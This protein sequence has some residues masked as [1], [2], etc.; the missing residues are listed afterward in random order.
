MKKL[1]VLLI[2]I[3]IACSPVPIVQSAKFNEGPS[4]SGTL[5]SPE[6][7]SKSP[8]NGVLV[9]FNKPRVHF[10]VGLSAMNRIEINGFLIPLILF[11]YWD[12]NIK[13]YL[14]T[15]GNSDNIFQ[16]ISSSCFIHSNGYFNLAGSVGPALFAGGGLILGTSGIIKKQNVEI[17]YM[18]SV[19]MHY[20]QESSGEGDTSVDLRS[21]RK[22]FDSQF[23]LI[24]SPSFLHDFDFL[25]SVTYSYP[26][27]EMISGEYHQYV[28]FNRI[29][30]QS[31][32]NINFGKIR[33]KT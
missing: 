18:P 24:F 33:K 4:L 9:N 10:G 28:N 30:F 20:Y 16:N 27:S 12:I 23:G 15:I 8:I 32:M 29:L 1:I 13:S 17:V 14:V 11:D 26:F 19:N 25:F 6:G 5:I 7:S 2:L 21:T 3:L 31:G 22:T